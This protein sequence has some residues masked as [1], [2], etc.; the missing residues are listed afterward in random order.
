MRP[1]DAKWEIS[2]EF[3]EGPTAN[4]KPGDPMWPYVQRY[5]NYQPYGHA[6]MDIACPIGTEVRA[7]ADGVVLWAD[8]GTKLPGDE[9]EAGY[10]AR[11]YLY[12]GFPGIV[13]VI[14]HNGW[15]GVYAHLS[16]NDEAPKGAR[17]KAGQLI[18]KSG[19]TGGVAPHLHV[20]ALVDLSYRTGGG[21]IYGRTNPSKY[22]G[23]IA[24]AGQTEG[25]DDV[26]T[27][28]KDDLKAIARTVW[29]EPI[30]QFNADKTKGSIQPARFLQGN[31]GQWI[32]GLRKQLQT[33]T[34]QNAALTEGIKALA[35]GQG[36]DPKAMQAA[37][38]QAVRNVLGSLDGD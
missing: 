11:W 20:E 9:S 19:N 28:D 5:G 38:E 17:V 37:M 18:G 1:V 15:I 24:P 14:Q 16:S 21:L 25:D 10:R 34:A 2:Q 31:E 7:I 26:A 22:F 23:G 35:L 36:A 3:G 29:D 6:G 12:K 13:T 32:I 8:W 27:L 30:Q 4:V 33:V